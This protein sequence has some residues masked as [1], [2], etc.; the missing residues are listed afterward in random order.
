MGGQWRWRRCGESVLEVERGPRQASI[1]L[2]WYGARQHQVESECSFLVPPLSSPLEMTCLAWIMK[3]LVM[4]T[5]EHSTHM[6]LIPTGRVCNQGIF[7]QDFHMF[8][9]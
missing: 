4:V 9:S 8:H 3:W 6:H 1:A 5:A 2:P 7:E